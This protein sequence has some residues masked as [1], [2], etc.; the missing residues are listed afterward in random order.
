MLTTKKILRSSALL[1]LLGAMSCAQVLGIEETTLEKQGVTKPELKSDWSCYSSSAPQ[2]TGTPVRVIAKIFNFPP[3]DQPPSPL[4]D[5]KVEVCTGLLGVNCTSKPVEKISDA[6]GEL[7]FEIG[8]TSFNGY[9]RFSGTCVGASG[10]EPC[11]PLRVY[12]PRTQIKDFTATAFMI[13]TS[14]WDGGTNSTVARDSVG[15]LSVTSLDCAGKPI[16][17]LS[18]SLAPNS[19]RLLYFNGS[20]FVSGEVQKSTF[21]TGIGVFYDVE[22]RTDNYILSA[23][24]NGHDELTFSTNLAV[25]KGEVTSVQI[26]PGEISPAP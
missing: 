19:G 14:L 7:I 3:P 12:P 15:D 26:T 10:D 8:A 18:I 2:P 20:G 11:K 17:G 6:T 24:P 22:P 4:P 16:E 1:S 23:I 13:A 9:V 5:I 25:L 21:A